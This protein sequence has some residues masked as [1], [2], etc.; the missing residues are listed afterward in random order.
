MNPQPEPVAT[1]VRHRLAIRRLAVQTVQRPTPRLV[2]VTLGGPQLD[3]FTS[4]APDDHV[5]VFF[6]T[7][8]TTEPV[9][10]EIG[11][12]G[13]VWPTSGPRPLA[14]NYTPSR[15][16]PV[17]SALQLDIVLHGAGVAPAW[18]T[19]ATAGQ[20]LGI[21][22]P[23]ESHIVNAGFDAYLFA[24]DETGLPALARWLRELPANVSVSAFVEVLDHHDEQELETSTK[25]TVQWLHRARGERLQDA[26]RGAPL[27]TGRLYIWVAAEASAVQAIR[28]HLLDERGFH[29]ETVQAR[30]YWKARIE[31]D[32]EP[33]D[34]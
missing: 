13:V 22:G 27:P 16:D 23:R 31:G 30:G 8:G 10:P 6:P 24:A 34:H 18:A 14:R 32:Q 15:F 9:L 1:H 33:H 20:H 17:A 21:G 11:E 25:L 4:L 5:R 3:G 2:R 29:P 12:H 26:I 19:D 7:P 28:R